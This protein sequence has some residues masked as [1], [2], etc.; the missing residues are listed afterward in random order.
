MTEVNYNCYPGGLL[1]PTDSKYLDKM[2]VVLIKDF[3]A[4]NRNFIE[5]NDLSALS[6]I[7]PAASRD[8][9]GDSI[10]EMICR[11]K[12]LIMKIESNSLPNIVVTQKCYAKMVEKIISRYHECNTTVEIRSS[13]PFI[14]HVAKNIFSNFFNTSM[15]VTFSRYFLSR[16]K[17]TKITYLD[18]FIQDSCISSNGEIIDRYYTGFRKYISGDCLDSIY[19]FP[20]FPLSFSLKIYYKRFSALSKS[21]Y[22]FI[23]YENHLSIFDHLSAIFLSAYLPIV[24]LKKRSIF[25]GVDVSEL[26][27]T[28]LR[29][30]IFSPLL[31][32]SIKKYILIKKL[33]KENFSISLV[34]EW[35][36]N[37][38]VDKALNL[39]IHTFYPSVTINGYQGFP[40]NYS[41]PTLRPTMFEKNKALLPHKLF[42]VGNNSYDLLR[43]YNGNVIDYRTGYAL[44]YKH[45]LSTVGC[46]DT[47]TVLVVL[48]GFLKEIES[49]LNLVN[50]LTN[51]TQLTNKFVIKTNP[52]V[53]NN[54]D[55]L[56]MFDGHPSVLISDKSIADLLSSASIVITSGSSVSVES[57]SLGVPT[58]VFG[59]QSGIT[60]IFLSMDFRKEIWEVLY[61][62][63]SV[64][65][66]ITRFENYF[67]S[68]DL[69]VFELNNSDSIQEIFCE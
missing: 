69:S 55:L 21:K 61:D 50:D 22:K 1:S 37:Q 23:C 38:A 59:S 42:L 35:F 36:E 3:N 2:S 48:T 7:L 15:E 63:Q 62:Y 17:S 52:I 13:K 32:K 19:I 54:K 68:K 11:V 34:I 64:M 39:A 45:L 18:T 47:S 5:D 41:N 8:S 33:K 44:R 67:L 51:N 49:L 10:F 43:E 40:M 16:T 65:N 24:K 57:I 60:N 26:Y 27:Q 58:V 28:S 14:Y 12:L 25:Q 46:H 29:N 20:T 30:S 56:K 53:D 31:A 4:L 66:F 9:T 6:L